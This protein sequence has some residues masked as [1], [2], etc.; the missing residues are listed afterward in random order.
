LVAVVV[1]LVAEEV[2]VVAEMEQAQVLVP[3]TLWPQEVCLV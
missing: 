1:G 2:G 3:A